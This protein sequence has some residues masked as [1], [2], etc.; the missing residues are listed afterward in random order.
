L[1]EAAGFRTPAFYN[2]A[3]SRT[4]IERKLTEL[5]ER[6][7]QVADE[8]GLTEEQLRFL[9]EEA[10]D[11]RLRALVAETP[12]EVATANESRRHA[13]A[14]RR[15][16]DSLVTSLAQLRAEQDVLLDRLTAEPASR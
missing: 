9:D 3:V 12:M 8:L 6:V 14:L 1:G 13:D 15:H 2:A 16:R 7:K 11:A 10:D 4:A 5:S